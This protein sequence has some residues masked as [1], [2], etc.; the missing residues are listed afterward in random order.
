M[1][2]V[3]CLSPSSL[4]L[5]IAF[6]TTQGSNTLS[7]ITITIIVAVLVILVLTVI[8]VVVLSSTILHFRKREKRIMVSGPAKTVVPSPQAAINVE[9]VK[10]DENAA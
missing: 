2:C 9:L 10:M 7:E 8:M 5:Y 3:G 1:Y 4:P 6:N